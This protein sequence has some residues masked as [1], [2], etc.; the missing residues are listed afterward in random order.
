MQRARET[1]ATQGVGERKTVRES[2]REAQKST[3]DAINAVKKA[4]GKA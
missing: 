4:M 2:L 3:A 1:Y